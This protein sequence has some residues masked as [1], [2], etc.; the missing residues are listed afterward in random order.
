MFPPEHIERMH[1]PSYHEEQRLIRQCESNVY[2]VIHQYLKR[3]KFPQTITEESM[4]EIHL[5]VRLQVSCHYAQL[6]GERLEDA[7]ERLLRQGLQRAHPI[8]TCEYQIQ[9]NGIVR[10][11]D[12]EN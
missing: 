8:T 3:K 4:K 1:D 5:E 2:N 6:K 12:Y 10:R 7:I 9:K 11:A